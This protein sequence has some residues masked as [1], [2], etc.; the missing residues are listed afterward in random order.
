MT[1]SRENYDREF[2]RLNASW[3]YEKNSLSSE[4]KELVYQRL[5]KPAEENAES[6]AT[7]GNNVNKD[8]LYPGTNVLINH[9]GIQDQMQLDRMERYH[10]A[11]RAMELRL[12][13][14][15]EEFSFDRLKSIHRHLF[16]D[17]Y[18]F[19]G[20]IR[21]TNIGK[22]GFWFCDRDMIG[23][24]SEMVFDEL[25]SD[26]YL[27][28]LSKDRFAEKAAYY[29][30]EINFMHPFRE[31]NGRT[32]R[33]FFGQLAKSA[34]YELEWQNVSQAEYYQAVKKTDDPK[35]RDELVQVFKKCLRPIEQSLQEKLEWTIPDRPLKLKDVLK[36]I[37]GLPDP[38]VKLTADDFNTYVDLFIYDKSSKELKIKFKGQSAVKEITMKPHAFMTQ[39]TKCLLIDQ[40]AAG[41]SQSLGKNK[42][43]EL[44]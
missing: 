13:P 42:G 16:Q 8:Y 3:G 28:G 25:K 32:T 21:T 4:E 34:G 11:F 1:I 30:T 18:P 29:Y 7:G 10:T 5:A 44:S 15:N 12:N 39:E 6:A 41:I 37:E 17:V 27:Q 22:N 24:L 23:R 14:E 33:E 19:A 38:K 36:V 26:R 40:A 31:G 43:L 2:E 20:E 35:L 9:F